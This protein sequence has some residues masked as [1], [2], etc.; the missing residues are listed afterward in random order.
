MYEDL[1]E[2]SIFD[3]LR[4]YEVFQDRVALQDRLKGLVKDANI[5][6]SHIRSQHLGKYLLERVDYA[7]QHSSDE[8]FDIKSFNLWVDGK[9]PD[10]KWSEKSDFLGGNVCKTAWLGV[11]CAKKFFQDEM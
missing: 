2:S 10:G 11:L 8:D 9:G 1:R 4:A 6:D 3:P 5:F 7:L